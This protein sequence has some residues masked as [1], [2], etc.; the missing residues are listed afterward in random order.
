MGPRL[1]AALIGYLAFL[2]YSGLIHVF[3]WEP[4]IFPPHIPL[5]EPKPKKI[6]KILNLAIASTSWLA[7]YARFEDVLTPCL[8]HVS[9]NACGDWAV[10]MPPPWAGYRYVRGAK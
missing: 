10:C 9:L 7:I 6:L 8:L 3:L 5:N 2:V 1:G 4:Y